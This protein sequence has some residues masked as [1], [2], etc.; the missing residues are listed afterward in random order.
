ML[1][2]C[3]LRCPGCSHRD[4]S[5]EE[6]LRA[7]QEWLGR[8]LAKWSS[9]IEPL[10][11]L[12]SRHRLNYREKACL[13]AR[14]NGSTWEFGF[15]IRAG[16]FE[17]DLVPIPNCPVHSPRTRKAVRLCSEI[18]PGLFP[19]FPLA[20][21][22]VSGELLTL[23]LKAPLSRAEEIVP[24]LKADFAGALSQ[25]GFSGFYLNFHPSA[26]NRVFATRAWKHVWGKELGELRLGSD[27]FRY[28]PSSFM[29]VLAGTHER[30]V[31]DAFDFLQ[32]ETGTAIVDLCSGIGVTLSAWSRAGARILGV[33]LN[34]EAVRCSD[35]NVGADLC[36]RGKASDRIPQ[37]DSWLEA[38][39]G[40]FL[41]YLNPTRMG[42]EPEVLAW[43]IA[44]ANR[45][46]GPAKI[47]YLS[48]NAISQATDLSELEN[49]GYAVT[50]IIPYDFFPQ[51]HHVETLA[52]LQWRG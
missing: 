30:S 49:A 48:C 18:L 28:G 21:L 3:E 51:T 29:Q 13:H 36:L 8:K 5:Q 1:P 14:W 22:A 40:K 35:I 44:R 4:L 38:V 33:E 16:Y 17:Y 27:I 47:A 31:K 32:P 20:F 10:E 43:L 46:A 7:K 52:T 41:L 23:V 45:G 2:G 25:A 9:V 50:R 15:L 37:I 42:L 19:G 34:G 11:E 12:D 39:S 24:L 26:G 6:S